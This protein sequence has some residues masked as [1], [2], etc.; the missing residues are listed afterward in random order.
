MTETVEGGCKCGKVRYTGTRADAAMFRCHCRDC[1][2]LTGT[3]HSEMLPLVADTFSI[4]DACRIYEMQGGSG[5]PTYSGFCPECGSQLM[6]RSDRMRD[7]VYVH[8][9]SLDDPVCYVPEKSIYADA[10]QDWDTGVI[11]AES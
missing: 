10:A 7:R 3:G 6:R 2:Q 1:Q 11:D 9:A 8:A 5:R 4:G